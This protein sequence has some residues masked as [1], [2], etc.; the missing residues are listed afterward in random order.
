L[1]PFPIRTSSTRKQ[2]HVSRPIGTVSVRGSRDESHHAVVDD[3]S[4][5]GDG[6]AGVVGDGVGVAQDGAGHAAAATRL[7]SLAHRAPQPRRHRGITPTAATEAWALSGESSAVGGLFV[8]FPWALRS[9]TPPPTAGRVVFFM[10]S[11]FP[12]FA[13]ILFYSYI[14]L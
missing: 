1:I 2:K 14:N 6:L 3:L 12:F 4:A 8:A 10:F 5:L 7:D 11:P 13:P 9:W